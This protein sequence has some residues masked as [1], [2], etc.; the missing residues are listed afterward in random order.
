MAQEKM[1]L[2]FEIPVSITQNDGNLRR[3]NSAPMINGLSDNSQV[4]QPDVLRSRRNST[5]VMNR[6][7]LLVPSSPIR[8]PSSRLHQIKREEGVDLINRETAHEREVQ[9][10]MQ[11]SQ[12][13][14][15]SLSLSDNDLDKSSSP[16]RIDFVP[17]SPAPSPTRGIGKQC[18]SPSL[19]IFVSSNGLPPS[20]IPSPTRRFA[21]RRSQSPINCI[22]PSALGPIKRKGEMETESQPKRLFQGTTNM[23][24]PDVTHL[25]D[26]SSC[27]T[28]DILDGSSSSVGSSSDSPAKLSTMTESP[29]TSSDSCSPFTSV[30]DL[31][32]K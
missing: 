4:F 5:T 23:L 32:P 16:K 14:D 6:H 29:V 31:S 2:D 20:P 13:W 27:L 15:E 3:S 12:S 30:D 19:Q 24:S 11:M 1:E 10:A 28:S 22:R 7:S 8:I 25:T 17:V 21:T 9:A 26:L 18:F